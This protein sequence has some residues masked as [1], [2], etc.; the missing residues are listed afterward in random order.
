[1]LFTGFL[2]FTLTNLPMT[3]SKWPVTCK[4][5]I[6]FTL[7]NVPQAVLFQLSDAVHAMLELHVCRCM[8]ESE[9]S[10]ALITTVNTLLNIFIL[11][12][13]IFV[14]YFCFCC[15]VV[16]VSCG[17]LS[18]NGLE[19]SLLSSIF[20]YSNVFSYIWGCQHSPGIF[21]FVFSV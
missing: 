20:M 16:L 15:V 17:T 2:R 19:S 8:C 6:Y 10:I 13:C 11:S 1:M 7:I 5:Q 4:S 21:Y 12:S 14:L 3:E 9:I 18:V